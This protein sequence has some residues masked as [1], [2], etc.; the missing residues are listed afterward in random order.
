[1]S[2]LDLTVEY[3]HTVNFEYRNIDLSWIK[4]ILYLK[5]MSIFIDEKQISESFAKNME[6]FL[7]CCSLHIIGKRTCTCTCSFKE[8]S[9]NKHYEWEI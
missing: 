3:C 6:S 8:F 7:L 1:M 2:N 5:K 9:Q 4:E